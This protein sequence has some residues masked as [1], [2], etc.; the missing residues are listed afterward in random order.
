MARE[1]EIGAGLEAF[2]GGNLFH[3]LLEVVGRGQVD[4]PFLDGFASQPFS[5]VTMVDVFGMTLSVL[6]SRYPIKGNDPKIRLGQVTIT[7]LDFR[8]GLVPNALARNG[9]RLGFYL[10]NQVFAFLSSNTVGKNC[11]STL[12]K[13]VSFQEF[14]LAMQD[15]SMAIHSSGRHLVIRP[16]LRETLE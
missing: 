16:F 5:L 13:L 11:R 12:G 7:Q 1:Q 8:Q 9:G 10:V 4:G 14:S 2:G 6:Q 15:L 3:S